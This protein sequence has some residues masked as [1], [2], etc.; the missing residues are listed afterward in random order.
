[1]AS[2]RLSETDQHQNLKGLILEAPFLNASQ[3][4]KD[5][6]LCLLFNNNNLIRKKVDEALELNNIR[7]NTDKKFVLPYML[8]LY[9]FFL[10][11]KK[12]ILTK[13]LH[14]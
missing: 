4:A 2:R 10:T 13:Q 3:A 7:F 11:A 12:L 1:V 9:L 6:H 5:Y 14:Y 8:K